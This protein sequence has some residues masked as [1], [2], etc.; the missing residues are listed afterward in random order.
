MAEASR[1]EESGTEKVERRGHARAGRPWAMIIAGVY[2]KWG[3]KPL[4]GL[5]SGHGMPNHLLFIYWLCWAA[6]RILVPRPGIAL[7]PRQ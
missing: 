4:E 2:S 1:K 3:R 7:R 6:C 5:R